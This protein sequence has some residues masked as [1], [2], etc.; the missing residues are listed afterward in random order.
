MVT[1]TNREHLVSSIG[2]LLPAGDSN[3]S[4]IE[5]QPQS[6]RFT[7]HSPKSVSLRKEKYEFVKS[8]IY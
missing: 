7:S 5:S 6:S 3:L 1:L 4:K 8:L 2:V